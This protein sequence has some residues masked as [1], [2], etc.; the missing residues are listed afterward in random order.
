MER[1]KTVIIV[2][3]CINKTKPDGYS[4]GFFITLAFLSKFGY[5]HR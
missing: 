1:A 4:A 2:G 3:I 5:I